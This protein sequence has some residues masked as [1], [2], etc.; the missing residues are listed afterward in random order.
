M[1]EGTDPEAF[2]ASIE[3]YISERNEDSNV[4]LFAYPLADLYLYGQWKDGE[5]VEGRI[6]NVKLFAMIGLFVL[7]IACINFMN[8]STAK[9]Q[10]RAKEVGVRKV[11]GA[12]KKSLVMQFMSESILISFF[13]GSLPCY[14]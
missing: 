1:R 5:L 13:L 11:A 10:K 6:K 7:I 2:S 14:W 9:S 8:L 4:R 12:D 3:N